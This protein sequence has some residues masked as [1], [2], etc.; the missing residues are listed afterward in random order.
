MSA[1]KSREWPLDGAI[2]VCDGITSE[3]E[4][5]RERDTVWDGKDGLHMDSS[6]W[7]VSSCFSV[8]SSKYLSLSYL[9]ANSYLDEVFGLSLSLDN[10]GESFDE[11]TE[12]DLYQD[13]IYISLKIAESGQFA[14]ILKWLFTSVL[15]L[16]WCFHVSVPSWNKFKCL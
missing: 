5:R 13:G 1:R 15:I 14:L 3:R 9:T 16:L 11:W 12:V 10:E 4:G 7:N 6:I 8:W 2:L